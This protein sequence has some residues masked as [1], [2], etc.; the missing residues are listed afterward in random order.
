[1][2][3]FLAL[4]VLVFLCL[5]V[6]PGFGEIFSDFDLEL[7]VM[8]QLVLNLSNL[9]RFHTGNLLLSALA[10]LVLAYLAFRLVTARGL[11][12]QWLGFLSAG[13]THDVASVALFTH[14]LADLL[15]ADLALPSALRLASAGCRRGTL[16]RAAHRLATYEEGPQTDHPGGPPTRGLPATLTAAISASGPNQKSNT[17]LLRELAEM[18][19]QWIQQRLDL[20]GGMAGPLAIWAAGLVVGFIV[21]SLFLPLID[22]I[23]GL[24]G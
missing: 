16:R 4:G 22:L 11:L 20:S 24:T 13:S 23:N 21:L 3:L 10:I 12:G 1:V 14:R 15:D 2:V 5:L 17:I 9:L 18:Y 8:T 19:A 6:V 7:P